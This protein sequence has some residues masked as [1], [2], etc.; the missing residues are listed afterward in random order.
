MTTRP[1]VAA[2]LATALFTA[3]GGEKPTSSSTTGAKDPK[4][5]MLAYAKCMRA[6]GVDMPDPQFDGN[7]VKMTGPKSANKEK[8]R[9]ADKACASIRDSVKP[10]ELSAAKKA[11]FKQ[12][13]L[14]NAQCMRDHGIEFPD[15]TFDENGGASIH[16]R[17]GSGFNPD[18][19]KFKAADKACRDTLPDLE[20][21]D[22]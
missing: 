13:A 15:P 9:T 5:A 18:S 19:P 8:V 21:G 3:C 14:K 20:E 17:K 12:A 4:Q 16:M 1:L 2:T 6:H 7:R 10:P 22:G 11:E